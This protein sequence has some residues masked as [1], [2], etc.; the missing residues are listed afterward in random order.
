MKIKLI[1]KN[2]LFTHQNT[3]VYMLYFTLLLHNFYYNL[4]N[5]YIDIGLTWSNVL[6]FYTYTARMFMTYVVYKDMSIDH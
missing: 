5:V 1:I 2:F 3:Y 4:I 6:L